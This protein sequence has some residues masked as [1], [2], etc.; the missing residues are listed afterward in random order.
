MLD[1]IEPQIW[2]NVSRYGFLFLVFVILV[3]T[4]SETTI[5]LCYFHLCAEDYNW[6]W[7]SFLT[8]WDMPDMHTYTL[9]VLYNYTVLS[10]VMCSAYI[11]CTVL[12]NCTV[13][14]IAVLYTCTKLYYS[15]NLY[16]TVHLLV[17]SPP[18]T[19]LSTASTT[20][21]PS[22]TSRTRPQPSCILDTRASWSSASSCW[23]VHG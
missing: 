23:Q 15:V 14:F 20:S 1:I 11:Y 18:S 13:L 17:A 12:Y 5:L 10:F 4:C 8:R 7:R 2:C 19:S 22:S 3:I 21:S 16:C 9:Y 6:W